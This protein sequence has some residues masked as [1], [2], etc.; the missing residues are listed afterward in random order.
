MQ[1]SGNIPER[2]DYDNVAPRYDRYRTGEGIYVP[3]L[4]QHARAVG[5]EYVLE[6]G[7]GTGNVS[8]AFLRAH[9]CCLT[10]L[11]LS[12]GM[13]AAA[14]GKIHGPR[15]IRGDAATLPFGS[16]A[17]EYA[18]GVFFVHHIVDL[19]RLFLECARVVERCIAVVTTTHNFIERH[20]MNAY[21]P[22]FATV[23]KTRFQPVEAI[24]GAMREAGFGRIDSDVIVAP[25]V[26]IDRAYVE[27]VAGRFISTY[28]LLPPDEFRYGLE[29]LR[30]DVDAKGALEVPA[31][32]E[33]VCVAGYR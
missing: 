27:K 22:S 18:F 3:R 2:I 16:D 31:Q 33:C 26:P 29:R 13:L 1:R 21:F 25:P 28:D 23:D 20:P 30:A 5:A 14:A 15:W 8:A 24:E 9:P 19:P 12:A 10:G 7:C 4:A 32:W 11:D 17:F 6:L